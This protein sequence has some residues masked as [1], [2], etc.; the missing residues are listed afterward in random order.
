SPR[1]YTPA[2]GF[3][4]LQT[5]DGVTLEARI[6]GPTSPMGGVV[7]CHPHPLYGGDMNNPVVTLAAEEAAAAG[8]CALRFNFR[9]VG[10]SSGSHDNG[11]AEQ[12]DVEAA[13]AHLRAALGGLSLG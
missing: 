5:S 3:F 1:P 11:D 2:V 12:R 13:V 4:T 8:L 9:G 6:S 10:R 7:I